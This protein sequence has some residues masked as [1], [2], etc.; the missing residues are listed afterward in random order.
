MRALKGVLLAFGILGALPRA[1]E[2]AP[3]SPEARA[4]AYLARE[5]PRWAGDNKCYSCHNNGDAAR[6]LFAALRAKLPVAGPAIEDTTRFLSKP[7]EWDKNGP[8]GPFKDKRLARVQF[9]AALL[10]ATETRIVT[11]EQPLRRAAAL[12]AELQAPDGFW[13]IDGPDQIGSP[14]T[15]GRPLLTAMSRRVLETADRKGYQRQLE[16]ADAWLANLKIDSL[17]DAAAVL[18]SSPPYE[19]G[20]GGVE[21]NKEQRERCLTLIR[22]GQSAEGG[23][24]PYTTSPPEPFDTAVVLLALA[25]EPGKDWQPVIRKGREFLCKTQEPEGHWQETTRPAGAESYAQRL[26][27]TGWATMA[28]LETR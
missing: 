23:W 10:A 26:S 13:A 21:K 14:V 24:G 22:K 4:I 28:L 18:I 3:S 12:V 11:D 6:A 9:A 17:L 5:V 16:Q 1:A 2:P 27:T 25:R 20:A 8:E 7:E 19:G 15:Y